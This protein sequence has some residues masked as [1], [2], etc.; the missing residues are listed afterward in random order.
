MKSSRS[1]FSHHLRV[2]LTALLVSAVSI[3]G[4]LYYFSQ[5]ALIETIKQSLS[6]QADLRKEGVL[7]LFQEQKQWMVEVTQSAGVA[8]SAQELISIYTDHGLDDPLYTVTTEKF[9]HQYQAILGLQGVKDLFLVT[10]E[11]EQAFSMQSDNFDLG[12]DLT[13]E[14][15]YGETVFSKLLE[16]VADERALVISY[17]GYV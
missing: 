13:A 9:R 14:G 2:V 16:D 5:Q 6:Y 11:G 7:T 8:Q 17:Y 3:G 1:I 12:N 15:F 10:P 4:V